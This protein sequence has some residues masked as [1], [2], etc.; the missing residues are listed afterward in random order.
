MKYITV[1]SRYAIIVSKLKSERPLTARELAIA[2]NK[3]S[4]I[5]REGQ[6]GIRTI[7]RDIADLRD[8]LGLNIVKKPNNTYTIESMNGYNSEHYNNMLE[9]IYAILKGFSDT[10]PEEVVLN[11]AINQSKDVKLSLLTED[12]QNINIEK[13]VTLRAEIRTTLNN[14]LVESLSKCKGLITV[15]R[16]AWLKE[17]L[18][19]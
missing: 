1:F 11:A 17:K 4:Q 6:I 10:K 13:A 8:G 5:S 18:G 16:P 9:T 2:V 3:N 12:N 19:Q 15:D 7:Q 14:K